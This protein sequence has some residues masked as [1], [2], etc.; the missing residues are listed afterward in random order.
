MPESKNFDTNVLFSGGAGM[1]LQYHDI[2]KPVYLYAIIKMIAV[3]ES[4]G[5]PIDIIKDMSLFK[6]NSGYP[7]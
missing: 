6:M 4:F 3:K 5:L 2:V 1:F 7:E